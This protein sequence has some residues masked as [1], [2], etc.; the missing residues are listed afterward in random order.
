MKQCF[1][2][3]LVF[4]FGCSYFYQKIEVREYDRLYGEVAFSLSPR[5]ID[6]SERIIELEKVQNE[7]KK[8]E[9]KARVIPRAFRAG[10]IFTHFQILFLSKNYRE[11]LSYGTLNKD[12]LK[13]TV[14]FYDFIHELHVLSMKVG[15]PVEGTDLIDINREVIELIIEKHRSYHCHDVQFTTFEKADLP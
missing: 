10:K 14:F 4:I 5:N 7:F 2:S 1:L 9:I 6:C 12:Q 3:L 13:D 11:A 8:W 15:K